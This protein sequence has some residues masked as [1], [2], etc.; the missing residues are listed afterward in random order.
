M[1]SEATGDMLSIN[2]N[3]SHTW[4]VGRMFGR[5]LATSN[6]LFVDGHVK[7]LTP[8]ATVAN[9]VNMWVR[10][11]TKTVASESTIAAT[12]LQAHLNQAVI[13]AK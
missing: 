6:Y 2:N 10:D 13:D 11:N 1:V 8:M 3:A 12:G 4:S 5:H 9:G 7:A